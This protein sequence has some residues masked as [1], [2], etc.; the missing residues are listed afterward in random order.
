MSIRRVQV[1]G[2][3]A[4][5]IAAGSL[6]V[7]AL[8]QGIE[9]WLTV[10]A[11]ALIVGL[12]LC[13]AGLR[14]FRRRLAITERRFRDLQD[15]S[16][17]AGVP[18]PVHQAADPE[19]PTVGVDASALSQRISEL[20]ERVSISLALLDLG[21][22]LGRSESTVTVVRV[23][24]DR[25][26]VL[27]ADS[28]V[29]RYDLVDDLPLVLRRLLAR[30][31][32]AR[33]YLARSM[34]YFSA[35]VAVG[36]ERD[37]SQCAL[38][39]AEVDLM[40]GRYRPEL[41]PVDPGPAVVGRVLHVVG[42]AMPE[43]QSGYTLRTHSTARAQVS[44]GL[45]P[46]VF[47]Q[48]GVSEREGD[49]Q[50]TIDGVVYHRPSGESI[51]TTG[52]S[53]WI[54]ENAEALLRVALAVRPQVLHAHSDFCNA[55]IATAVGRAAGIP[56]VYESRGFWEE[57][58]LSRTADTYD[59]DVTDVFDK[60][61]VPES[62]A[63]R[64]DREE[65]AR[66]SADA[67]VTLAR[68]MRERILAAGVEAGDITI[69]PNAVDAE[70][71]QHV[72]RSASLGAQLGIP[73]DAIVIGSV[74]SVVEYEGLDLL[75]EAFAQVRDR[76]SQPVWLLIVGDGPVLGHLREQVVSLGLQDNVV[77]AGRVPHSAIT[78][79]YS[80]IDVFVVP[81]RDSEVCRLVTPL[82]P[83]EA[84]AA[85]SVLVMSDLAALRE[86]AEDSG[87]AR[88]FEPESASALRVVLLDLVESPA[89][90]QELGSRGR[91]WARKYRS[92]DANAVAYNRVYARVRSTE[93]HR[94]A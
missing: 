7:A 26:D 4:A 1:L 62:Y 28:L 24:V 73:S 88:L 58:W 35:A 15:R 17:A 82:K 50:A 91:R 71:F 19:V 21:R 52:H 6:S 27:D 76:A 31:L 33:G 23:L 38:R 37:A 75:V 80:L 2:A 66:L 83:F 9:P 30:G 90:R 48:L 68:M 47:V 41:P 55:M 74:T 69:V 49:S 12:G 78:E 42:R 20:E 61:G 92:W 56:V 14:E 94:L 8:T 81:R 63:W 13:I 67:T 34:V 59:W 16:V 45:Q 51:F 84:L 64:R 39:T 54:R 57:T 72:E 89:T 11:A 93:G 29:S 5:A 43:T 18:V 87:S 46:H 36:D 53:R 77:L 32:R 70:K 65:E 22:Q 60:Y 85:G 86:I 40:S 25:G 79:Y 44:A 10:A 3:A